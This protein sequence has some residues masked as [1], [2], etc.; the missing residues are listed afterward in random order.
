MGKSK[1]GLLYLDELKGYYKSKLMLVLWIGLPLLSF[2]MQ[3]L[4]PNAEEIPLSIFVA[5]LVGSI[6]GT[7]SS[8]LISTTITSERNR[9]VYDLFLIRPVKRWEIIIAKYFA[10]LT[11]LLF[12]VVISVVMGIIV[13]IIKIGTP[14]SELLKINAQSLIVAFMSIC[15]ACSIGIFFGIIIN[16]VA[17]SAV[18]SVY[19]GNQISAIVILPTVLIPEINVIFYAILVGVGVSILILAIS[20]IIFSKKSQY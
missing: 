19:L 7:L 1:L 6:G 2:L 9:N 8:V 16:S 11:C 18:L 14:I 17:V 15:I 4:Q 3:Y 5:I 12:A 13:D 20:I 10:V